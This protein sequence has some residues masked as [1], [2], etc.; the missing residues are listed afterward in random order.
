[1][2]FSKLE[3]DDKTLDHIKMYYHAITNKEPLMSLGCLLQKRELELHLKIVNCKEEEHKD[4]CIKW[5]E[6]NA[7]NLRAYINSLID[8]SEFLFMDS[9]LN[10]RGNELIKERV[11]EAIDVWNESVEMLEHIRIED[12]I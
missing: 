1:M 8:I 3:K 2:R 7:K 9:K 4:E 10:Y 6:K 11:F 12:K 5:I